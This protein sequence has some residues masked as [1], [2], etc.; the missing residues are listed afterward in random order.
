[1]KFIVIFLQFM[2]LMFVNF[3]SAA[4]SVEYV[5]VCS[6][7][8]AGWYY[9]PGTDTCYNT[10]TGMEKTQTAHGTVTKDSLLAARVAQLEAEIKHLYLQFGIQPAAKEKESNQ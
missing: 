1:M 3:V 5:K 8:G 6:L 9:V 10:N 7:Y 2:S 4:A